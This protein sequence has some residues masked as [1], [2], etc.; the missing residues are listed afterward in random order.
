[1]RDYMELGPTPVDE[2]CVQITEPNYEKIGYEECLRYVHQLRKQFHDRPDGVDI[3]VRKLMYDG[4]CGYYYEA[5]ATYDDTK[6]DQVSYVY[7]M[8]S[9]LPAKWE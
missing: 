7:D 2:D 1:M 6:E 5:V 4:G 9:R 3:K 8:E